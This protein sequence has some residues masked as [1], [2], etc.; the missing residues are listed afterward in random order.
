MLLIAVS[1]FFTALSVFLYLKI[2]TLK[3]LNYTLKEEDVRQKFKIETMNER[4]NEAYS[5]AR[6]AEGL[7]Q[8]II[9]TSKQNAKLE[10]RI[11][12][13]IE[14]REALRKRF[15]FERLEKEKLNLLVIQMQER[16]SSQSKLEEDLK[17]LLEAA[18]LEIREFNGQHYLK[19]F[20]KLNQE[21]AKL[22][23]K[24]QEENLKFL[25]EAKI[26][27]EKAVNQVN[28]AGKEAVEDA[29]KNFIHVIEK[30]VKEGMAKIT[31]NL[32]IQQ[33]KLL[34]FEEPV[35]KFKK[36]F[37]SSQNVGAAGE[38]TLI[39]QLQNAG[40]REGVDYFT[41]YG[42]GE[43]ERMRADVVILLPNNNKK[44]I[45]IIDCKSSTKFASGYSEEIIKSIEQSFNIFAG[46]DYKVSV[47]RRIKQDISD[48]EINQIH[49]FM[50]LPFDKMLTLIAENKP[51][52]LQKTREKDIYLLT[53]IILNFIIDSIN[54]YKRNLEVNLQA[55]EI[56][57]DIKML[58]ERMVKM[59]EFIKDLGKSVEQ[60][61]EKYGRL[62]SSIQARF[63]PSVNR[64]A[65][66]L[67]V[68]T[69]TFE[70]NKQEELKQV[71]EQVI[72]ERLED[73]N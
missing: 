25:K 16:L 60:T 17:S 15:E 73:A 29:K 19:A 21:N 28:Q 48:I 32:S 5:I 1:I 35:N 42:S 31:E 8:S 6:K 49:V 26:E 45:L 2:N 14:E 36:I 38:L 24:T 11:N 68:K 50:Y 61:Y 63:V 59:F 13:L 30:D 40:F 56:K 65:R 10:E 54:I 72:E 47:E 53:P 51:E 67:N 44:D 37:S 12:S 46:K 57:K 33:N 64:V 27:N 62:K 34:E 52:F 55:E 43:G 18:K 70:D 69:I 9:E 41:Q 7:N 39:N 20:E 58:T 71:G 23:E 3:A 4:L 22:L 66:L